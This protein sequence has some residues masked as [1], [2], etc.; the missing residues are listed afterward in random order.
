MIIINLELQYFPCCLNSSAK[1]GRT[2]ITL[3]PLIL[4]LWQAI[5]NKNSQSSS[6][7]ELKSDDPRNFSMNSCCYFVLYMHNFTY[8]QLQL[9]ASWQEATQKDAEKILGVRDVKQVN[10]FCEQ[11]GRWEDAT[12]EDVVKT[13]GGRDATLDLASYCKP[14]LS[15][16]LV[17]SSKLP[18]YSNFYTNSLIFLHIYF[19]QLLLPLKVF[20]H[21]I[22]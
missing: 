3:L 5:I 6:L 15:A 4:L 14:L 9:Y 13:L 7:S 20:A 22:P 2:H 19:A 1:M 18:F 17:Q 16:S 11:R 12:Q 10:V 8:T 21:I